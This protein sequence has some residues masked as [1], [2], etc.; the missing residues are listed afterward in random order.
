MRTY[1]YRCQDSEGKLHEGMLES[2]SRENARATLQERGWAIQFLSHGFH[3]RATPAEPTPVR[4]GISK[5]AASTDAELAW[6]LQQVSLF[7]LQ[8]GTL[9][10]AGVGLV[11]CL[12]CLANTEQEHVAEV[13]DG[14]RAHLLAGE[15]LSQA[16]ARYPS[17]FDAPYRALVKLGENTG[18]LVRVFSRLAES[19]RRMEAHRSRVV[20][21]LTYPV[22]VLAAVGLMCLLLTMYMVP[23]LNHLLVQMGVELPGLTRAVIALSDPRVLVLGASLPL[24]VAFWLVAARHTPTGRGI[25]ERLSFESPVVGR[26]AVAALHIRMARSLGLMLDA[27]LSW[28]QSVELLANP[29]CGCEAYDHS[30]RR[31]KEEIEAGEFREAVERC[32][33]FSPLMIGLIVAGVETNSVHGLL[34]S[35]ADLTEMELEM[36]LETLLHLLEPAVMLIMGGFV[37]V[38]VLAAFLPIYQLML[39]L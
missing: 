8:L 28:T 12:D 30:L 6:S 9:L 3:T 26:V 35:Y 11:K 18:A 22:F 13:V 39:T 24:L 17:V 16:M 25:L 20:A 31:L 29:T 37:A 27:G 32:G 7:T 34:N 5:K 14:L 19:L 33:A 38:I 36:T 23:Q 21:A 2:A 4:P 10:G 1:R 15:R